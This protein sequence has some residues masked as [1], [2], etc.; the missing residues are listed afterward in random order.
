MQLYQQFRLIPG[1]KGLKSV[2]RRAR[3]TTTT[4]SLVLRMATN[5]L[6]RRRWRILEP[7]FPPGWLSR[8]RKVLRTSIPE[9]ERGHRHRRR[10]VLPPKKHLRTLPP[11]RNEKRLTRSMRRLRRSKTK[12]ARQNN[13]NETR[14]EFRPMTTIHKTFLP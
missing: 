7:C 6:F 10:K 14:V 13:G 2:N 12:M 1:R 11:Q 5:S 9:T 8:F 3:S 4:I